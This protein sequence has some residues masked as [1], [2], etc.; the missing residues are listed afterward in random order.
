MQKHV[1]NDENLTTNFP[2]TQIRNMVTEQM[3]MFLTKSGYIVYKSG[4][5][6]FLY[7]QTLNHL[8]QLE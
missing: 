1:K 7:L 8:S 5:F 6:E 2:C 4:N 3:V